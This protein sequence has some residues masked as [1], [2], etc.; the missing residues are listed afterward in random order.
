MIQKNDFDVMISSETPVPNL[1][2]NNIASLLFTRLPHRD[3]QSILILT[4]VDGTYVEVSLQKLRYI[5]ASLYEEFHKKNIRPGDTVLLV[6]LSVNTEL[7]TILLFT[8]LVSYGARVLFP[9]FVETT[10]LDNWIQNTNCSAVIFPS[11]EI[12]NLPGYERQKQVINDIR[13]IAEKHQLPLFDT[14]EDFCLTSLLNKTDLPKEYTT[15]AH[16]QACL[17]TTDPTTESVIFTTS[18]TSGRSKLVLYEQGAFL[19]NC[20]CWQASGLYAWEKLGGRS[21]LDILPHT[22]SIRAL[23]NSY[24]TGYPLCIVQTEW[25]KQ[26]PQKLLPFLIKMRPEVMTLAP[27][28]FQFLLELTTLVPE[29]KDLAFSELRTVVSTSA[30]YSSTIA[31]GMK[32]QFN[33]SLHNAYGLT[34]TQQVLT[35][36][37][38][39]SPTQNLGEIDMG[40]PI[41]GVILGLKKYDKDLYLLYVKSPYGHKALLTETKSPAE[42]FFSTGDIVRY[43]TPDN[44]FYIGREN[45]DFIKSGFGAKV[46]I[47]YLRDYYQ[48]LYRDAHHIEYMA[49]E[50]FNFSIGIAALI[51]ISDP[52]LP[53]GRVTDKKTIQTFYHRIITINKRLHQR[54]EPFEYEQWTIARFLLINHSVPKTH[55]GTVSSFTIDTLF[56]KEKHDLIHSNNPKTGVKNLQQLSSVILRL[57]LLYTP[58][59]YK[60]IRKPLLRIFLR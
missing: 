33:L 37:L 17:N 11:V 57:L 43:K 50:T 58:L 48:D 1:I 26:K 46:S 19:R 39:A 2:V 59:R 16:V 47:A 5:T 36:L 24:W 44:L 49:Y 10:E 34:E 42:E 27:N 25:I 4:H 45:K 29:V 12:Q 21:F 6:T 53:Q 3:E 22:V 28:S 8:G 32:K 56:N 30:P 20:H 9:M 41:A 52:S 13:R 60:K 7:Y 31:E 18:G 14:T 55:K 38:T 15:N 35:T 23:L 51:F 40:K 54:L